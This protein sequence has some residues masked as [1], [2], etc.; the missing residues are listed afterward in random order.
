MF[1]FEKYLES[2]FNKNKGENKI[3]KLE[4]YVT[5]TMEN[6]AMAT[7]PRYLH[8]LVKKMPFMFILEK[9]LELP[10]NKNKKIK[11]KTK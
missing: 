10:F 3:I 11:E 8:S 5:L 4:L 9:Y 6:K 2:P 1:I 7:K